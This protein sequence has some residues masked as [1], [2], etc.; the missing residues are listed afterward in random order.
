[1][2]EKARIC[3]FEAFCLLLNMI[4]AKIVL[5]FPRVVSEDVGSAAWIMIFLDTVV[6]FIFFKI[7]ARL[8]DNFS[9]K[10]LIDISEIALKK[11]GKIIV[12]V[13]LVIQFM[14]MTSIT[15]R[16]FAEDIKVISLTITP[17]SVVI[18]LFCI[19]MVVGAYLGIG[20][21][22]RVYA[23]V[24]PILTASLTMILLLNSPRFDISKLSP[25]LGLGIETILKKGLTS[26]SHFS[27]IIVILLIAP[28]LNNKKSFA[29]IGR[30][31]IILSGF[32]LAM[33]TTCY[34]LV[35]QYPT[36]TEFFLPMYQ[37][38]RTISFGRFFTRIESAFI[39]IWVLTAFLYLSSSLYFITYIFQRIFNLKYRR[40]LITPF[41]VL[42]FT[43]SILPENLYSTLQIEMQVYSR[44]SWIIAIILP[45]ILIAIASLRTRKNRGVENK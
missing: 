15:L 3:N 10:D 40:P 35:Y 26:L 13:I 42:L 31:G 24:V 27:E 34:L 30:W 43:L 38:A 17:I 25:W 7:I 9:G 22:C 28:F 44:F 12:G 16:E 19:A 32:F 14:Y 11:V 41:I 4:C 2:E 29:G 33:S 5:D 45:T 37:M 1:M 6:V 39:F 18:T 36:S 8:Y 20:T 23:L 21:I